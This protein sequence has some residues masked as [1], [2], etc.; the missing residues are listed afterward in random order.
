DKDGKYK[1]LGLPPGVYTL[2]VLAPRNTPYLATE[3]KV[4]ASAPGF[5]PVAHDIDVERQPAVTGR[6]TDA[7]AG[8]PAQGGV[9]YR[10]LA[11]N[12]NLQANPVLA[13][14]RFFRNHTPATQTDAEG[15]F[16]LPVLRG[17]GVLL[18]AAESEYLPAK[19]A[20]ADRD[21]GVADTADPELIDCRPFPAWPSEFHAYR[22]IDIREGGDAKADVALTPGVNRPLLVEF[23]DG[24]VRDATVL[25]LKPPARDHGAPYFPG[26]STV[27][28]LA[29]DEV[30]RLFVS[31]YDGQFAAT[32][33]VRGAETG[34]G[35]VK[36][37]P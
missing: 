33:V 11:T 13:E 10:P 6:L 4:D 3:S 29:G 2:S 26:Q 21:A 34:P 24:K 31:T 19:L 35:R 1:L 25:G 5:N 36:L 15:R 9:G 23:P 37:K 16:M 14:P 20:Q 18:V 12:A 30:R 8:K 22:L 32:A 27:A 17:R 28:G 7:A